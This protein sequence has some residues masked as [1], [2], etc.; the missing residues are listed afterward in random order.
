MQL[1]FTKG[2][3]ALGRGIP[4]CSGFRGEDIRPAQ[5]QGEVHAARV[6]LSHMPHAVQIQGLLQENGACRARTSR[7]RMG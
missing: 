5:P 1:A 3:G 7:G 6:L 2:E 4:A